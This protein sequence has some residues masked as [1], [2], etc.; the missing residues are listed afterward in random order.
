MVLA[1]SVAN[2][3]IVQPGFIEP[4]AWSGVRIF[5]CF[6][7]CHG[8]LLKD[9]RLEACPPSA[10]LLEQKGCP[11]RLVAFSVVLFVVGWYRQ[12]AKSCFAHISR[13]TKLSWIRDGP[14]G[15]SPRGE[16]FALV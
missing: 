11:G 1:C 7:S 16:A 10:S 4:G 9:N 12:A 6:S 15:A 14:V 13:A 3:S 8:I 5:C 2:N